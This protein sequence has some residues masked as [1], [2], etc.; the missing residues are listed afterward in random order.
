[1]WEGAHISNKWTGFLTEPWELLIQSCHDSR[2]KSPLGILG[3][4]ANWT[5]LRIS[6]TISVPV[7]MGAEAVALI[8]IP[9][10][11]VVKPQGK[12]WNLLLQTH[13]T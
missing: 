6:E 1:M 12:P 3:G 2:E 10:T 4:L 11:N 7:Y 13:K 9:P 5:N 8:T